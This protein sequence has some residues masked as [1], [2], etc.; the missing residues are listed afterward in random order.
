MKGKELLKITCFMFLVFFMMRITG[1]VCILKRDDGY[2]PM[3]NIYLQ[4]EKSIDI[5]FLGSS[6]SGMG[7]D[8]GFLWDKYGIAGYNLW[9][10]VQP[11]WNSYFFLKEALKKQT[12]KVVVLEIFAITFDF[13][14]SD[15]SR[16]MVNTQGLHFNS[17][18]IKAVLISS[19]KNRWFDMFFPI[20][21]FHN[22][23]TNLN[24]N[25]FTY[26]PWSKLHITDKGSSIRI[27]NNK[28]M[29]LKDVSNINDIALPNRK[30]EAYLLK[31]IELCETNDI[32]LVLVSAPNYRY[33]SRPFYNYVSNEISPK[34]NLIYIDANVLDKEIGFI[35][36][37]SYDGIHLNTNGSRKFTKYVID[38]ILDNYDIPDHHGDITYISWEENARKME[39][40]YAMMLSEQ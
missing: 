22:R 24:K 2:T 39:N 8:L 34:Y 33:S 37:D 18:Y 27:G 1:N 40:D 29:D 26:F 19:Q 7:F 14:Y 20:T 4:P 28:P 30:E 35:P 36:E 38:K 21:T 13:N 25:D 9:G 16:Q 31:I 6:L 12:P 17:N 10:S 5:L 15:Y 32:P 3:R 11:Y 23:W